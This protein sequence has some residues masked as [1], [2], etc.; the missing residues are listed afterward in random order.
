[1]VFALSH[2]AGLPDS[3]PV[4]TEVEPETSILSIS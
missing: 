3:E 4:P 1:M 2:T